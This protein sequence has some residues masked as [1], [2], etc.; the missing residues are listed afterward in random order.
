VEK[1]KFLDRE[2]S[3]SSAQAP[4]VRREVSDLQGSFF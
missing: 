4:A 2:R 3:I 1:K